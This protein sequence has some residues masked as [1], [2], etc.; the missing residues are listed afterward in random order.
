MPR[1]WGRQARGGV[2]LGR[3]RGRL[4]GGISLEGLGIGESKLAK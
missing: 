1:G 3:A 4:A 2:A